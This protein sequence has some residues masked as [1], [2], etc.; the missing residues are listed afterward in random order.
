MLNHYV[1]YKKNVWRFFSLERLCAKSQ[2][3]VQNI[4][5]KK[6]FLEKI[7]CLITLTFCEEHFFSKIG[8]VLSLT[9]SIFCVGGE[10]ATSTILNIFSY[11]FFRTKSHFFLFFLFFS[12]WRFFS[13]VGRV[14]SLPNS[15][16]SARNSL[17]LWHCIKRSCEARLIR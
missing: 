5:V 17:L 2:N 13:S 4:F 16:K 7:V 11:D 8:H 3:G 12:L 6:L 1:N 14:L 15:N 9:W 10:S